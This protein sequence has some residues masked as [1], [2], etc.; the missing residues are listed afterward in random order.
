VEVTPEL[1]IK[2]VRAAGGRLVLTNLEPDE[3]AAWRRASKVAYLRLLRAGHERLERSGQPGGLHLVLKRL[4]EKPA[5][6]DPAQQ[7]SLW[8]APQPTVPRTAEFLDRAVPVP[9]KVTN[10]HPIVEQLTQALDRTDRLIYG[11]DF[12]W[13]ATRPGYPLVKMRQIWQAL[14]NEATFRGYTV[15]FSLEHRDRY[16]QGKLVVE[17]GRDEFPIVLYG[18]R[19]HALTLTIRER[20]PNRRRGYDSW[21]ETLDRPLHTRLGEVFTH[22]E[23][24]ADLL[25]LQREQEHQRE[26]EARRRRERI[27]AEARRRYAEEDRRAVLARRIA[28][29]EFTDDARAYADAL[30]AAADRVLLPRADEVRAWAHWVREHA[31]RIDP[32]RTLAGMPAK[33]NPSREELKPFLPNGGL[34]Y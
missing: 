32:R 23:R 25:I 7:V 31:D 5:A 21:T 22:I 30:L 34:W 24:W 28:E 19:K 4:D 6:T 9:S 1:L 12:R 10:P 18:A 26:L 3:L 17:I 14:I 33:P 15:H 27:E 20:H 16:E 11:A 13:R 8:K 29:V 2:R